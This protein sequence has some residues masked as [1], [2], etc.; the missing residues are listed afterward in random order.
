MLPDPST[1]PLLTLALLGSADLIFF[2]LW[3]L[4]LGWD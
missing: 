1:A 3:G 2:A 4:T